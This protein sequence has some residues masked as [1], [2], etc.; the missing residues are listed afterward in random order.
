MNYKSKRSKACDIP[1]K[2][3]QSV[4]NRDNGCCIFCGM[5]GSPNAHIVSRSHG[6]LGIEQNIVTA[7]QFC[8][9]RMDNSPNREIYLK[10]AKS[11]LQSKYSE[12]DESKLVYDKWKNVFNPS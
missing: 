11:Y 12:W 9:S 7:C 8:H 5:Q 4:Y 3:K 1:Q 6:G 2:V 10:I